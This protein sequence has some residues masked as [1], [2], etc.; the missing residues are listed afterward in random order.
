MSPTSGQV[1]QLV[2]TSSP[3]GSRAEARHPV[4]LACLIH[5][6]SVHS[7][8]GSNSPFEKILCKRD[9][10]ECSKALPYRRNSFRL[11]EAAQPHFLHFFSHATPGKN[12]REFLPNAI[13]RSVFKE[14]RL[15]EL[16]KRRRVNPLF[17]RRGAFSET[18]QTRQS[19]PPATLASGWAVNPCAA[20]ES[21]GKLIIFSLSF[22]GV[23][24]GRY[25]GRHRGR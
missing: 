16:G 22:G 13:L 17:Q 4:R 14:Q 24:I 23:R 18:P 1:T 15:A 9:G 7:E 19:E 12:P 11:T 20:P 25:R 5:A 3:L 6:A 2:R 21:R 8:P 10:K